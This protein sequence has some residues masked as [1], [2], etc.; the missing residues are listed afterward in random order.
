M[1]NFP[2]RIKFLSD[3]NEA[4]LVD[5]GATKV[6]KCFVG[7]YEYVVSITKLG[8]VHPFTIDQINSLKEYGLLKIINQQTGR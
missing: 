6:S 5:V 1:D 4:V 8:R 7:Y 3:D 2:K